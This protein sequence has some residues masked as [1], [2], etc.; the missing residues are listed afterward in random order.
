MI[1]EESVSPE[2]ATRV[3]MITG[4]P[5]NE[6]VSEFHEVFGHAFDR[7]VQLPSKEEA[8]LRVNM[9]EEEVEELKEAIE[10]DNII[11]IFDALGDIV[12]L[13][14]GG[15]ELC[16]GKE[17]ETVMAVIHESNMSKLCQSE[18]EA[19]DYI[20]ET[21]DEEGPMYYYDV[22]AEGKYAGKARLY[23]A[24]GAKKGKVAKSPAYHKPNLTYLL[25]KLKMEM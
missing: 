10:E 22:I 3:T 17:F 15:F 1:N 2:V 7:V 14:V 21:T 8:K 18:Q 16:G 19:R 23:Y 6:M 24:R 13:A 25:S 20:D 12:Y 5:V 9:I 11:E 4:T